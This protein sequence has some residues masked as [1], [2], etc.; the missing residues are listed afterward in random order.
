LRLGKAQELLQNTDYTIMQIAYQIGYENQ[1][2]LT[3]LF[4]QEITESSSGGLIHVFTVHCGQ[5]TG[6]L[7]VRRGIVFFF[8]G[9]QY[10][11]SHCGLPE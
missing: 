5:H 7:A 8:L 3:R 1:S 10:F 2:T 4:Q 9:R 6:I 11:Y